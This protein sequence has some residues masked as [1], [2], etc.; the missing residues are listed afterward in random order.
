MGHF[1]L[2]FCKENNDA[3]VVV[4]DDDDDDE[5]KIM[6]FSPRRLSGVLTYSVKRDV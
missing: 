5:K 6:I 4:V 2:D 1:W 3:D